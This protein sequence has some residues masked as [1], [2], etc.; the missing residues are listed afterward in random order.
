MAMMFIF[1][2]K[3]IK[4]LKGNIVLPM[5]QGCNLIDPWLTRT[6]SISNSC[7]FGLKIAS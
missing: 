6:T 3:N 7:G 4:S 1:L 2:E 5:K